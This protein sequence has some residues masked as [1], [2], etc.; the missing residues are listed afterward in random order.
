MAPAG[1][2]RTVPGAEDRPPRNT[3]VALE[4]SQFLLRFCEQLSPIAPSSVERPIPGTEDQPSKFAPLEKS[5]RCLSQLAAHD[6]VSYP[7]HWESNVDTSTKI[8]QHQQHHSDRW[9][10]SGNA[11]TSARGEVVQILAGAVFQLIILG[12]L[13]AP[14]DRPHRGAEVAREG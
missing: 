5:Y 1:A 6:R 14:R 13:S 8:V 2:P 10:A 3:R 9:A 7:E 11:A 12:R 4:E